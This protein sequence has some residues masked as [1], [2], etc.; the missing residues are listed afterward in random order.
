MQQN[1]PPDLS[2]ATAASAAEARE[3]FGDAHVV[4]LDVDLP[5]EDGFKL[6]SELRSQA[7][8][9][10]LQVVLL[11]QAGNHDRVATSLEVGA[12][13]FI[14]LPVSDKELAL[15]VKAAIIRFDDE[16][17]LFNEREYYRR[18]VKQEEELSSRVL[19][20][21]MDLKREVDELRRIARYDSLSGLL[22]RG[23]LFG[24][25]ETEIERAVRS[26][27]ALS[28]IMI[29]IDHFKQINDNH[30]HQAGDR[31]IERLGELL[32]RQL[33]KYDSAGRYGG[34]E[35]FVVLADADEAQA[36][37][38]AGR[39]RDALQGV[40]IA[41]GDADISFTVSMGIAEYRTGES[42]D[43]WIARA[44]RAMYIAKRRGRDLIQVGSQT[45]ETQ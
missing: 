39:F 37:Q 35:F 27:S 14:G 40:S 7:S 11:A 19:D 42:R 15:R 38:F 5:D 2:V 24:L 20:Q 1:L 4:L 22:N 23:S 10:P 8:G 41:H 9:R 29:D 45:D 17:R 30:G 12:D 31:V 44:D 16:A 34:E 6:C 26:G 21:N 3:Q 18:A 25:I 13:D 36:L 28:G 43:N 33:R 32:Q